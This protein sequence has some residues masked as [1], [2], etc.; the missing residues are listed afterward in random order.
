MSFCVNICFHLFW[1]DTDRRRGRTTGLGLCHVHPRYCH[2]AWC[3]SSSDPVQQVK[4]QAREAWNHHEL[5]LGQELRP[6]IP[7]PGFFMMS[8]GPRGGTKHLAFEKP[9]N[10]R[11][12]EVLIGCF[13][14]R[15]LGEEQTEAEASWRGRGGKASLL[16]PSDPWELSPSLAQAPTATG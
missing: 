1:V 11:H 12:A 13:G 6:P 9:H 16:H 4:S 10:P 7:S 3:R 14:D 2:A 5:E 15:V 8:C